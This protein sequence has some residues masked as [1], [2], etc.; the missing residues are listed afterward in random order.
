[1][2]FIKE[3]NIIENGLI[4]IYES[5]DGEK[6]IDARLL[7][8]ELDNKRQF[9]DWIKQ[10][11]K[12]YGFKAGDDYFCIKEILDSFSQICEKPF[13]GRPKINYYLTIDMAK[14]LCMVEN[15]EK[16][17]CIRKYFIEVEKRYRNIIEKPKNIFDF[18]HSALDEIE[19]NEERLNKVEIDVEEIKRK[20][21]VVIKNDYSLAS[22][23]AIDLDLY[24]ESNLPHSNLVG[25]IARQLGYKITYKHYY[26]D[27][28]I[29]IVP[30]ISKGNDYY[31][32]YYK[33]E[34]VKNI[35]EWFYKNKREIQYKII[36]ERNT[37]NGVKGAVREK[38]YK[39]DGINYKML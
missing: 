39:I 9:A 11:I 36:Y 32:V 25:A 6:L 12:Q 20:I 16:G 21:D 37:K 19:K 13:G 34:A 29:A 5:K 17:R 23:I 10:R 8:D 18:L 35:K 7:H 26:E 3:M 4:P 2:S 1:M 22:D 14:E 30:D 31:Q 15:N 38:G 27:E 33:Q 28:N 24:S